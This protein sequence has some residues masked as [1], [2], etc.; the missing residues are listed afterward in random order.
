[1]S[2]LS[3]DQT[4]T[5]EQSSDVTSISLAAD[6]MMRLVNDVLDLANLRSGQLRSVTAPVNLQDLLQSLQLQYQA[7]A[8][9]EV[10]FGV[11]IAPGTPSEISALVLVV[12][13]LLLACLLWLLNTR[14]PLPR[15]LFFSLSFCV[16]TAVSDELRL[17]QIVSNGVTNALKYTKTGYVQMQASHVAIR[18]RPHLVVQIL[19][20]GPGASGCYDA[21]V[22]TVA[23]ADDTP[24]FAS[25]SL[26]PVRVPQVCKAKTR[27][28]CS[29][30]SWLGTGRRRCSLLKCL[31]SAC[32]S[33]RRRPPS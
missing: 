26:V 17:K 4:L 25:L 33:P 30:R 32:C 18:G 13:W 12:C 27:G 6:Q 7:M 20:T 11:A 24:T 3:G 8:A 1:M 31:N 9:V 16:C 10:G 21:V 19:N 15:R 14:T 5:Q 29:T 2:F 22:P 23:S 28:G